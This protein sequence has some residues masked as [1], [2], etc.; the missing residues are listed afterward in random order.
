VWIEGLQNPCYVSEGKL[1]TNWALV[2]RSWCELRINL[3]K[4]V[5]KAQE[6]SIVIFPE[7]TRST[8]GRLGHFKRGGMI[9]V[10][11][12]GKSV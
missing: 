9:A 10:L 8:D 3:L 12:A 5:N 2:Q 6:K 4:I 11:K 7:G 1:W